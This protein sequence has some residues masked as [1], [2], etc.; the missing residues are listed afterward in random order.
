[1]EQDIVKN[2][3]FKQVIYA[4]EYGFSWYSD[5]I[6]KIGGKKKLQIDTLCK[7][8]V[9]MPLLSKGELF[10][11]EDTDI[12]VTIEDVIRT[13]KDNVL[14]FVKP[15]YKDDTEEEMEKSR[16]TAKKEMEKHTENRIKEKASDN[17]RSYSKE[18]LSY[19]L[20]HKFENY[21]STKR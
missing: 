18:K 7:C 19:R 21:D 5:K 12:I 3:I 1:M 8:E 17:K 2:S 15:K 4:N 14:Y 10:Y 20:F 9:S 13:S 16:V 6:E 11:L